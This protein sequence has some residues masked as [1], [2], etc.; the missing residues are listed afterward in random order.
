MR[1]I[2]LLLLIAAAPAAAAPRDWVAANREPLL[3]EYRELLAI[4]NG[5]SDRPNIRRNAEH[6][7]VM[8][9]RRG[10]APRLLES[11][12]GAAP[13]LIYGEWRVPGAERTLVIYAHYDGQPVTPEDWRVTPPFRP[14][15][16][17]GPAGAGGEAAPQGAA[18]GDDWR[19]YARSAS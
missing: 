11:E 16:L 8:M 13:P 6:I 7:V 18:P 2:V 5:A 9:A 1:W 10:L 17:T 3:R 15:L 19:I 12:D 14:L 4:P